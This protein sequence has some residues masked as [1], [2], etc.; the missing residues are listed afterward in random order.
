MAKMTEVMSVLTKS[1][2]EAQEM[3]DSATK[4]AE[5]IKQLSVSRAREETV[6][7]KAACVVGAQKNL[8]LVYS[9]SILASP[10]WWWTWVSWKM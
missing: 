6:R 1:Q 3:S 8:V 2:K 4:S 7:A 10:K 5:K 9:A